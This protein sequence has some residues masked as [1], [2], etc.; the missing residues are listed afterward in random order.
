MGYFAVSKN[1]YT[2]SRKTNACLLIIDVLHI[3]G[4]I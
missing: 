2:L 1:F 4:V 3:E